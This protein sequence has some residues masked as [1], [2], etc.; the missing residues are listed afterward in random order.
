MRILTALLTSLAIA[1]AIP[2]WAGSAQ[3]F[4]AQS[5]TQAQKEGRPILV[6]I[7]ASWCPVCAAQKPIIEHLAAQPDF[8]SLVIFRVDFDAQKD[9]VRR[10]HAS[11]Q[12]TLIAFKGKEEAAR[13]VGDTDEASIKKLL[14]SAIGS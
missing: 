5:F 9:V 6:D 12:S 10:F 1:L 7:T 11:S 8:R 14:R 3:P 2:V 13:S 4:D